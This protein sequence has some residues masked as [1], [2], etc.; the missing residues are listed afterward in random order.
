MKKRY[1]WL[2]L[3]MSS[4]GKSIQ[5][6]NKGLQM[7]MKLLLQ[8]IKNILNSTGVMVVHLYIY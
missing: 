4:K 1:L 8:V 3:K 7:G 2:D 6:E 5:T